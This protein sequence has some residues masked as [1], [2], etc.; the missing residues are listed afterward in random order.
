MTFSL[1]EVILSKEILIEYQTQ[2]YYADRDEKN[3]IASHRFDEGWIT[4]KLSRCFLRIPA[5]I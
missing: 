2:V 5:E 4:G 3:L 1:Q